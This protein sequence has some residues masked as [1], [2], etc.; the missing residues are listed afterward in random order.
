MFTWVTKVEL[1]EMSLNEL[2]LQKFNFNKIL[3]IMP[4]CSKYV[5]W[6]D[7]V[8]QVIDVKVMHAMLAFSNILVQI[9]RCD[10][11]YVMNAMFMNYVDCK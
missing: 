5:L 6:Y 7:Q 2:G 10:P 1:K 8:N 9:L 4:L 11:C 3:V